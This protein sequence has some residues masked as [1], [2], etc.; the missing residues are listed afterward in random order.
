[1]PLPRT[2]CEV[3]AY[4]LNADDLMVLVNKGN[5]C[6]FRTILARALR[7]DLDLNKANFH[8]EQPVLG[9]SPASMKDDPADAGNK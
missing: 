8:M 9:E 7:T 2:D 6:V 4:P 5:V 3:V 1:M